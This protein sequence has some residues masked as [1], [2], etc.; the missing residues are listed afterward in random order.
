MMLILMT[1]MNLFVMMMMAIRVMNVLQEIMILQMMD[2]ILM[3]MEHVMPGT[4][5]MIMM[6]DEQ[7]KKEVQASPIY[8]YTR[9]NQQECN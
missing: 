3:V 1:M 2:R 8:T 9:T 5:T 7:S 6:S 4:M